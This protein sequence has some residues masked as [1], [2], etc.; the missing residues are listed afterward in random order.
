M[1]DYTKL[2]MKYISSVDGA[3]HQSAVEII[4]ELERG[5]KAKD[6]LLV[7]HRIGKSPSEKLWAE[8]DRFKK[9]IGEK[10]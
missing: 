3:A 1:K 2:Q 10:E 7:C 4:G 8:L 9:F 6:G 5:I